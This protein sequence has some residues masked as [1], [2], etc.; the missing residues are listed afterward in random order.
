[1]AKARR[2]ISIH[3]AGCRSLL[4]KYSKGGTGSLVKCFIERIVEDRTAGELKCPKCG[5]Q[6]ARAW[7][8]SGKPAH[9]IISGKVFTRGMTRK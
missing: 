1:M 8:T 7:A 6:F 4:Y 2:T 5:Q 9:R 3:C